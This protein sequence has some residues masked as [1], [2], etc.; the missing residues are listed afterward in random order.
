MF[1]E[2]K[3][4]QVFL[5]PSMIFQ[6][7]QISLFMKFSSGSNI[8]DIAVYRPSYTVPYRW[9]L[10][11]MP[12]LSQSFSPNFAYQFHR[13]CSLKGEENAHFCSTI[14]LNQCSPAFQYQPNIVNCQKIQFSKAIFSINIQFS[15]GDIS[16]EPFVTLSMISLR[17]FWKLKQMQ[18]LGSLRSIQQTI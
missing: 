6:G 13:I 16:S 2:L 3:N 7:V 17:K 12:Y 9:R 11:Y 5:N 18:T 8:F 14:F 15:K 4:V 10:I 1:S